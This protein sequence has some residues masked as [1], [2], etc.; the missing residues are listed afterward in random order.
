MPVTAVVV[1]KM[2]EE[3]TLPKTD[4]KVL[5]QHEGGAALIAVPRYAAFKAHAVAISRQ[6]A[7]FRE[8]AGNGESTEIPLSVL[9]PR[10]WKIPADEVRVVFAHPVL[11]RPGTERVA[12]VVPVRSLAKLL[13]RLVTDRIDIEHVYDY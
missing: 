2:P 10:G 3:S 5:A 12:F 4:I 11:T 7:N 6:G 8:I 13:R 1:D 9:A